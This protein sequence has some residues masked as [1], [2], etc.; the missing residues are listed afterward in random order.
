[1]PSNPLRVYLDAD[2]LYRAAT[3]SHDRTASVIM[4]GLARLTLADVI[5]SAI[6]LDEAARNLRRDTPGAVHELARFTVN[7]LRIVGPPTTEQLIAVRSF[8]ADEDVLHLATALA[9]QARI[10]VTFNER[11]FYP[12]PKLIRVMTPGDL[13]LRVRSAVAGLAV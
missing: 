6:A 11:H 2:V 1:M 9:A 12:P 4:L 3:A 10:L 8:A 13:V 5:T 7:S